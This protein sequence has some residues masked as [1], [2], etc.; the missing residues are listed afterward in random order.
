VRLRFEAAEQ[1]DTV[2]SQGY[3]V[4]KREYLAEYL[5]NPDI[6]A[7]GLGSK[8]LVRFRAAQFAHSA[9]FPPAFRSWQQQPSR[10]STEKKSTAAARLAESRLGSSIASC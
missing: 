7:V 3:T 10:Y 1:G 6:P 2:G 5:D 8:L 4:V 9:A